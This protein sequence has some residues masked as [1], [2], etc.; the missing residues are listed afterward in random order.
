FE[1]SRLNETATYTI[2]IDSIA[3]WL[4]DW[5]TI[6][7]QDGSYTVKASSV[8]EVGLTASTSSEVR[9]DNTAPQVTIDLID[10]ALPGAKILQNVVPVV[11][12]AWDDTT[13]ISGTPTISIDGGTWT[14]VSQ[15]S[16]QYGTHS[17][18]TLS[19]MD[20]THLLQIR[21]MDEAG[22][23]GYSEIRCVL[24]DNSLEEVV[25]LTPASGAHVRGDWIVRLSA[26]Q[27]TAWVEFWIARGNT[28]TT[29]SLTGVP[30]ATTTD[31]YGVD[32]W[33]GTWTT[34]SFT[35]ASDY[36]VYARAYNS[37]SE[38][39]GTAVSTDIEIDNTAATITVNVRSPISKQGTITIS[40]LAGDIDEIF[41]ECGSGM[42]T[43]SIGI[44]VTSPFGIW[45]N[46]LGL[47]DGTYTIQATSKDEVGNTY[48]AYAATLVDNTAPE[49]KI[50]APPTTSILYGTLT[51][52]FCGTE[53]TTW[54]Y[55][56]PT[57]L[58]DGEN[59]GEVTQWNSAGYGTY[60]WVTKDIP[61]GAHTL[62]IRGEDVEGNIGYSTIRVVQI[63]NTLAGLVILEPLEDAHITG[64]VTIR[65]SAP[66]DTDRVQFEI[67]TGGTTWYDPR[68]FSI[69]SYTD[70]TKADGWSALWNTKAFTDGTWIIRATAFAGEGTVVG[71][72]TNANI[73]VDNTAPM[74][75]IAT[76]TETGV[77]RGTII[78]N[79]GTYS[80]D[81]AS[82]LFEYSTNTISWYLIGQD[83]S[84]PFNIIWNTKEVNNGSY[85]VKVTATDEVNLASST[86]SSE[87]RVD[88]TL[89]AIAITYPTE[90]LRVRSTVTVTFTVDGATN[91]SGWI[92]IDGGVY[93]ETGSGTYNWF[94]GTLTDGWHTI[95]IKAT[96]LSGNWGYSDLMRVY[97]DNTRPTFD[98]SATP[99]PTKG[100]PVIITVVS[101]E[102][103]RISPLVTV[104]QNGTSTIT[105]ATFTLKSG[106]TSVYIG[107][108]TTVISGYDGTATIAVIG[109]DTAE[110]YG[111][112]GVGTGTFVVDT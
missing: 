33:T 69:G 16:P 86:T 93:T 81:V 103:L 58:I 19:V 63:D 12:R 42:G 97:V 27:N 1:Y 76:I 79:V 102:E 61:D 112:S 75:S 30:F 68:D 18:N 57:I 20:T 21:A 94:T 49:F 13:S 44:D 72:D 41:F 35:D 92:S 52:I 108:Y 60:T 104:T 95:K 106:Y 91:T 39:L 110:L 99:D 83:T 84:A 62:Q 100:G 36:K 56:T 109:T 65:V 15:W 89:P 111:N 88:N 47:K 9:V 98:I 4:A 71:T 3:P 105:L 46:T 32:G 22:N 6:G 25:I 70:T 74:I 77:V 34:G 55:G 64:T 17:W 87:F 45:W 53:A 10:G 67:G 2:L 11:F 38:T 101:S 43:Y 23:I 5:N 96:E 37:G 31:T 50:T 40:S 85:T 82:V 90:G 28:S 80:P 24:V 78:I 8:D 29:W 26:P 59:K 48:T 51:V 73:E 14:S 107:T 66:S 54:F 7:L